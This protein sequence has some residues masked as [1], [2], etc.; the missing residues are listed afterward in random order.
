MQ[1]EIWKPV[2]GYEDR[3]LVSTQGKVKSIYKGKLKFMGTT[4]RT[5]YPSVILTYGTHQ[6]KHERVHRLVAKAFIP[7]PENKP[8]V[9]HVDNDP[10][11]YCVENLRWCYPSENSRFSKQSK[12]WV[13]VNEVLERLKGDTNGLIKTLTENF[14]LSRPKKKTLKKI[15]VGRDPIKRKTQDK[16]VKIHKPKS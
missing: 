16:Q 8:F 10:L 13:E 12:L 1:E 9:D 3:Y 2:P 5:G 4:L 15:R 6:W 11:N 7:N 14:H